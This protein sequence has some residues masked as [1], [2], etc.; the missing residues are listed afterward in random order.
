MDSIIN[1]GITLLGLL[2]GMIV[3]YMIDNFAENKKISKPYC[4]N[5]KQTQPLINYFIAPRKCKN[6]GR[7]RRIRTVITEIA[8]M[9]I[10]VFIWNNKI[11]SVPFTI[12]LL[13]WMYAAFALIMDFET[14]EVAITI[15]GILIFGTVGTIIW[16]WKSALMGGVLST[17]IMLVLYYLGKL[18]VKIMVKNN[19]IPEENDVIALGLGDVYLA[20]LLGLSLGFPSF[21]AGFIMT[22]LLGGLVSIIII[23]V[24]ALNRKS[25]TMTAIAYG[26]YIIL[27]IIF[28][29]YIV[30]FFTN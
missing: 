23:I 27:S 21:F 17:V 8:F 13:F 16:G 28:M 12:S 14:K 1:I 19:K 24:N 4:W 2:A 11:S 20:T 22:I 10:A 18:M 5:C 29:L 9:I 3:N 30:R 25:S 7:S 6:C 15:T 26:P